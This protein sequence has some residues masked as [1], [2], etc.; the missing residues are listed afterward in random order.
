ASAATPTR[1]LTF[2]IA[3]RPAGAAWSQ[4]GTIGGD[5]TSWTHTSPDPAKTHQYRVRARIDSQG[6]MTSAYSTASAVVQLQAPPLAPTLVSPTG[7]V[8][9]D[10]GI[11]FV[12]EHNPVD[13]SDQAAYRLQY[14][15][16]TSTW[17]TLTGTTVQE[18]T[19]AAPGVSGT[20]EWRVQ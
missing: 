9:R 16:G 2:V 20:L 11:T 1:T 7:V 3:D 10:E 6:L 17:T 14:R 5:A 18:R 15:L 8:D 19:I 4:V 13:T 12:W